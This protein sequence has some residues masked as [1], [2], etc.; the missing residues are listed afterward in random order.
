MQN[1]VPNLMVMGNFGL[2]PDL[3][4]EANT[5]KGRGFPYTGIRMLPNFITLLIAEQH[6]IGKTNAFNDT[7]NFLFCHSHSRIISVAFSF[8]TK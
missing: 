6:L 7:Y 8:R 3:C 1:E 2:F 5:Y 4:I